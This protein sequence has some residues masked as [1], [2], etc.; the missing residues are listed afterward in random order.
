[1]VK[2]IFATLKS[3]SGKE[4]ANM[5]HHGSLKKIA[6]MA[7]TVLPLAKPLP[8]MLFYSGNAFITEYLKHLYAG[9]EAQTVFT[10]TPHGNTIFHKMV[11][12]MD[13]V[14]LPALDWP[15]TSRVKSLS[16]INFT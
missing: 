9:Y 16:L 8:G 6:G 15:F 7:R 4:F 12:L 3:L 10:F 13:Q 2:F 11:V 14:K 1:M 5:A